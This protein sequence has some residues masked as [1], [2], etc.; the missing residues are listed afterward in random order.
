MSSCSGSSSVPRRWSRPLALLCAVQ[1]C[2]RFAFLAMLPLFV[3]YAR[4]RLAMSAPMA[5]M[6]LAILQALSYLGGLPGGWLAD[7]KLGVRASTMLG[8]LL[9]AVAYGS[10]AIDRAWLFWPAL[11]LMVTG[12]SLFRPGLHV[13]IAQGTGNDERARERGFLWHYLAANLGYAAGALFGEWAHVAHGWASL[14]VGAAVA[15]LIGTGL[16]ALPTIRSWQTPLNSA[17]RAA[18]SSHGN[19][20]AV[21][22][23]CS[24]AV[25]FW[26]TA[27]QAGSS[28]AVFAAMN[29]AQQITLLGRTMQLGPGHFAALH[30]LM[31]IAMLPVFLYLDS[32]KQTR[33]GST[34]NTL[35]WGYV[36]T[37]GAFALMAAASLRGG[38]AGRVSGTW[39]LGCYALLSLAE[40]LL[41]PLGVSLVTRLAPQHKATQA[42]GLWFAGSA[43]GNGLAALL[44][45]CWDH[46]PH[47]RYFALLAALSLA[48]AAAL[49]SRRRHLD[50]LTALNT[51]A[52]SQPVVEKRTQT[53]TP[54]SNLSLAPSTTPLTVSNADQ[55]AS[56]SR[57]LLVALPIVLPGMLVLIQTLPLP[58]RGVSA[59][60]SGL[61]ILLGGPFLF[62]N[63]LAH[64]ARPTHASLA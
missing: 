55:H 17:P 53:M 30:G 12:H 9:L 6:M 2:E 43:V 51:S 25:V 19:M 60:V 24:V 62:S 15:S 14:F 47:H 45:L 31:V 1:S 64:W 21:W 52:A 22:L 59:I 63:G 39:L 29:T 16:L 34:M 7:R 28:L 37:A 20:G 44:G 46:W 32:R 57:M 56:W 35:I 3:L 13:L 11:A 26:L 27:Q 49:L 23:L 58:V 5:L 8:A 38:D 18:V 54:T 50:W 33:T 40:I 36:G 10:L 41:A 4:D 48:A 42:V 61:S